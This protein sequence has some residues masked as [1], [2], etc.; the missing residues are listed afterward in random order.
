MSFFKNLIS[1]TFVAIFSFILLANFANISIFAAQ[2]SLL[3]SNAVICNTKDSNACA[4]TGGGE[5]TGGAT[6]VVGIII[7]V[8]QIVTYIS[9]A[10]AVLFLVYGGVKYLT[11]DEKGVTAARAIIQNAIIGLIIT[12]IAYSIVSILSGLLSGQFIGN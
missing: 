3:P 9:G 6:G 2:N 5:I 12:V 1:F 4:V 11:A 8:A 10:L 7:Q